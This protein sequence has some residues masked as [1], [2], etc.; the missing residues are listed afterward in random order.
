MPDYLKLSGTSSD[1][2][3]HLAN[4][5]HQNGTT[6]TV[7][8]TDGS[9]LFWHD[10][11]TEGTYIV[12]EVRHQLIVNGISY[13][14]SFAP[15]P[16]EDFLVTFHGGTGDEAHLTGYYG[17]DV[18]RLD[19]T[20]GTLS[21]EG[22]RATVLNTP[23][24]VLENGG[25]TGVDTVEMFDSDGDDM[26]TATPTQ[27]R[28]TGTPVG[29]EAFSLTANNFDNAHAYAKN[30]GHDTADL[31]GSDGKDRLKIYPD[32]VK[33]IGADYYSRAKFFDSYTADIFIA[34]PHKVEMMNAPRK[35]DGVLRGEEYEITARGF[36]NVVATGD[37]DDVA[38]LYDSGDPGID[39]WA[40]DYRDGETWS[41][42]STPSR[43]LYEVL[44][45]GQVGGYGFNGGLGPD[46][47]RNVKDHSGVVDF[48]FQ[49]GY[50]EE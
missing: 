33:M 49:Y 8:G 11:H 22:Y 27:F 20:G 2:D 9:D 4:L 13:N 35:A 44:A 21:G 26:L 17:D 40:A 6:V 43:L 45:F 12:G 42:M 18:A 15:V 30:G 41:T 23:T 10:A 16:A 48:A 3:L 31:T 36:R 19:P 50:W 39:V 1:V 25:G 46:H 7:H 38:K 32:Y 37:A 14:F 47:G 5:V 24:V 28:L 29:G 34:K